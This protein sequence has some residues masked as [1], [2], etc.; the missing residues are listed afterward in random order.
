[1]I[2]TA[3]SATSA[4]INALALSFLLSSFDNPKKRTKF[5]LLLFSWK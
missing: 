4:T 3:E 2:I 5:V 1:M